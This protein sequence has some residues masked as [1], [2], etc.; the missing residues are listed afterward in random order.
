M[1]K[2]AP[3]PTDAQEMSPH[4]GADA[5]VVVAILRVVPV[6]VRLTVVAVPVAVQDVAGSIHASARPKSPL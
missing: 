1:D 3:N 5:V 4:R 6:H 2:I